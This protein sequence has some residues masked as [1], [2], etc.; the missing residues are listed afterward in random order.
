[1]RTDE[2][3]ESKYRLMSQEFSL[4]QEVVEMKRKMKEVR[5]L[6]TMLFR[7]FPTPVQFAVL[8]LFSAEKLQ[9]DN[10]Q[11]IRIFLEKL[12]ASEYMEDPEQTAWMIDQML[13]SSKVNPKEKPTADLFSVFRSSTRQS[14]IFFLEMMANP[15]VLLI[16]QV[17]VTPTMVLFKPGH[18]IQTNK[19]L[20]KYRDFKSDFLK[21]NFTSNRQVND[22]YFGDRNKLL[23]GNV[24][25]VLKNGIR[26]GHHRFEFL[27][28][29][30]SQIK[31]H[32]AWFLK[33]DPQRSFNA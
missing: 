5:E 9:I 4:A 31:S 21:V 23:L 25:Q 20:R 32:S 22:F 12:K 14:K 10:T 29:S 15:K 16:R 17:N 18:F 7:D 27:C 26:V 28:Y 13:A 30:N 24:H 19:V 3:K 8:S 6:T 2:W 33:V 11:Q 1:M